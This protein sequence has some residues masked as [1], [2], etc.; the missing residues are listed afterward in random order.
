MAYEAAIAKG[1]KDLRALA[2]RDRYQVEF[3]GAAY[4]ADLKED[5]VAV[6]PDG[7]PTKDYL[8]I[9]ILHYLAGLLKKSFAPSGEWVSFKEIEAGEVYFPAFRESAIKPLLARY[10]ARPEEVLGLNVPFGVRRVEA[11]DIGVE[12]EAL[13][14]I[15][16]RIAFW[17]P[18]E[19]FGPEATILF[20]RN[21]TNIYATEDI[22]VFLRVI[23]HAL[24]KGG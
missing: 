21:L 1:W 5:N 2:D 6:Y 23:A 14:G 4:E 16:V 8:V 10:G 19:E 3:L 22:A 18:D 17:R 15:I 12:I 11:G 24:I 9:L 20:D 13:K 7:R